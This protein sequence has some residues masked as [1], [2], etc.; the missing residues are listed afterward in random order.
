M[1]KMHKRNITNNHTD[2][3]DAA[4]CGNS[5]NTHFDEMLSVGLNQTAYKDF[6]DSDGRPADHNDST[7]NLYSVKNTIAMDK[8]AKST[9]NSTRIFRDIRS[10][11]KIISKPNRLRKDAAEKSKSCNTAT[12]FCLEIGNTASAKA[13]ASATTTKK[14]RTLD[15]SRSSSDKYTP[16]LG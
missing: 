6:N 1:K 11:S 16:C 15:H 2:M 8:M 7:A 3:Y 13:A 12:P 5:K 4:D 10:T 14:S 9:S